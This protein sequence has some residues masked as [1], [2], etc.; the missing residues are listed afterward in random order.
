MPRSS[1]RILAY[2]RKGWRE[3]KG[4]EADRVR[5]RASYILNIQNLHLFFFVFVSY[6]SANKVSI[7][8]SD[9]IISLS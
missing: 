8:M 7:Y 6:S 5:R 4:R 2:L 9:T 1:G 3:S